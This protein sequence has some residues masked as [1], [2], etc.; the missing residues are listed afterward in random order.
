M[1][2]MAVSVTDFAAV[3][4]LVLR[5]TSIVLD[6]SRNY[7]IDARLTPVAS[8]AGFPSVGDLVDAVK[9][10][11][12]ADLVRQVCEAMTTNETLFF[13]EPTTFNTISASVL[14][15]LVKARAAEK[16]LRVWSAAS[17][18]GQEAYS[19]AMMLSEMKPALGGCSLQILAT[20]YCQKVL[21]Y[22][23]K[24]LYTQIEINRGLPT[25]LML[26]YFERSGTRWQISEQIRSMVD[27]RQLNLCAPFPVLPR[28][29]I[30]LLRNVLIYF[31][32]ETR[33]TIFEQIR[34]T[35]QPD[36]YLILGGA[37]TAIDDSS[38]FRPQRFGATTFYQVRQG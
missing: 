8:A 23:K 14:P 10:T 18:T 30:I 13:R 15:G 5:E 25:S 17:S 32:L 33:K 38:S 2:A 24:G 35:L 28:F 6:E 11:R 29:D 22:A 27:F 31:S 1:T 20:D 19:V 26:K 9:L 4:E 7:L 21:E 3:R 16:T 37:E 12:R 34:R 36:G